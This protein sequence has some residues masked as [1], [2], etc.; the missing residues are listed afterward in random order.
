MVFEV[1]LYDM[2]EL[3][4]QLTIRIQQTSVY[5]KSES[6]GSERGE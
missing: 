6:R 1:L 2:I 4:L 3:I 5:Y